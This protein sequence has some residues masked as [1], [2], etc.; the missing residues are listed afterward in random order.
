VTKRLFIALALAFSAGDLLPAQPPP[1]PFAAM[2]HLALTEAQRQSIHTILESHRA[3]NMVKR[4]ALETKEKALWEAMAESASTERHLRALHGIVSEA[5]LALLLEER[6]VWLEIQAVLSPA[7][8]AQAKEQR[9]TLQKAMDAHHAAMDAFG[10][11]P[12]GPCGP[13]LP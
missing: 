13:F 6:A 12:G 1:P 2:K 5:R 11:K 3:S 4:Q 10:G 7:Q 8:Q 9:Q